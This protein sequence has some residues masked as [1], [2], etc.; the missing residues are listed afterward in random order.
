MTKLQREERKKMLLAME[1]VCRQINDE[2]VL[3]GWLCGGVPDGDIEYGNFDTSQ[4]YDDDYMMSD[5]GFRDIMDCFLRRMSAAKQ[6]GGLFCG[7]VVTK[8]G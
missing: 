2:D 3:F 8:A 4:I 7:G 6:S 1:Y 5:E